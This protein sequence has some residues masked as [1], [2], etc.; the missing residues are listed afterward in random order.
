VAVPNV[1]NLHHRGDARQHH[2]LV[3]PVELVGFPGR[4]NQRHICFGK[5][6]VART[7]PAPAIAANR[8]VAARKPEPVLFL[9]EA[10]QRQ[11]LAPGTALIL[12]Q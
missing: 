12:L 4:I 6:D 5:L 3:A 8:I 1:C 2:N 9:P 7:L 10:H 11:P